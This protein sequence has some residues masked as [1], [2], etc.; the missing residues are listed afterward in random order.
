MI[1]TGFP[2]YLRAIADL[3]CSLSLSLVLTGNTIGIDW[4]VTPPK[5]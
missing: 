5:E 2:S 3:S 4:L 1:A